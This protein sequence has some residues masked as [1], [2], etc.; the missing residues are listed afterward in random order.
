MAEV[1][2]RGT[3]VP[4]A[5]F[6]RRQRWAMAGGVAASPLRQIRSGGEVPAWRMV[7]RQ[8]EAGR[9][10]REGHGGGFGRRRRRQKNRVTC[11]SFFSCVLVPF[12]AKESS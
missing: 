6:G 7:Q 11:S 9:G 2:A 10:G 4:S 8:Q 1:P 12:H 3:A 5:R